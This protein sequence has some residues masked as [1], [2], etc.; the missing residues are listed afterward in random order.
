MKL[1]KVE[2][3]RFTAVTKRKVQRVRP[4]HRP[5]FPIPSNPTYTPCITTWAHH[6]CTG[7]STLDQGQDPRG[8][9]LDPRGL[10]LDPRLWTLDPKTHPTHQVQYRYQCRCHQRVTL[11]SPLTPHDRLEELSGEG[12]KVALVHAQGRSKNLG[13]RKR[14]IPMQVAIKVHD[15][16]QNLT[17]DPR[18]MM[19]NHTIALLFNDGEPL[20]GE[21]C[22]VERAVLA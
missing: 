15:L 17:L 22:H 3:L 16:F 4:S 2:I 1:R 18:M 8:L 12:G 21:F 10:G 11:A 6:P 9:G 19:L 20:F 5:L 14:L 13:Y 7:S